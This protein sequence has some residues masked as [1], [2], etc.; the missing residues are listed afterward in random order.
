MKGREDEEEFAHSLKTSF[1]NLRWFPSNTIAFC[2]VEVRR[3]ELG[4]EAK[5]KEV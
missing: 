3:R 4:N 5:K 2:R 1:K